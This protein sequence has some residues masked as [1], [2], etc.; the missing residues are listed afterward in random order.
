MQLDT[1]RT[2][3]QWTSIHCCCW[4]Q[5]ASSE[6]TTPELYEFPIAPKSIDDFAVMRTLSAPEAG[7]RQFPTGALADVLRP[8]FGKGT[9]D[10]VVTPWI[11]DIVNEDLPVQAARINQLL[12]AA[13]AG[14]IS[15]HLRLII[16]TGRVVTAPRKRWKSS[17][18]T[19]FSTPDFRESETIPY[20]CS[21]ASRH[22]RQETVF[23]FAAEK[24]EKVKAPERHKALPDWIVT[25]KEPVPAL[26]SFQ[27]RRPCRR[28]F[29]RS[30][31]R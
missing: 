9:F 26:E 21:P 2:V 25:G 19:G 3:L 20:M 7:R 31:C 16:P 4:S 27:S 15:V 10:T 29:T 1:G 14:S 8:P 13:V 24:T 12:K 30:S 23:T 11:I 17:S 5:K 22:G 18:T 6:A 28:R